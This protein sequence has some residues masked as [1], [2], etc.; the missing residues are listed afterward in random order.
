MKTIAPA[1]L[2]VLEVE[3]KGAAGKAGVQEGDII[4]TAN[5]ERTYTFADLSSI[6]D[7]CEAGDN[8]SLEIYRY[9]DADGALLTKPEHL[10]VE[11]QL[12]ILD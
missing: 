5:G 12:R 6:I 2:Q 9:Y 11:V 10:T 3:R 7:T 4:Y 1:G 8:L